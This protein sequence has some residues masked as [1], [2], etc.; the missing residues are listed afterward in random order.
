MKILSHT[1]TA[2]ISPPW[3]DCNLIHLYEVCTMCTIYFPWVIC[4]DKDQEYLGYTEWVHSSVS[5]IVYN[6][7]NIITVYLQKLCTTSI[8]HKLPFCNKGNLRL[9]VFSMETVIKTLFC[10][11]HYLIFTSGIHLWFCIRLFGLPTQILA[12]IS[13][14]LRF[15]PPFLISVSPLFLRQDNVWQP[16]SWE[17][18]GFSRSMISLNQFQHAIIVWEIWCTEEP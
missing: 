13:S 15:R 9:G 3:F 12:I 17:T 18:L 2:F 7:S 8:A 11:S 5:L 16:Q 14:S 6:I 10:D 4:S 1:I